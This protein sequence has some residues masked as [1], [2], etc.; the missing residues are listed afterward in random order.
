MNIII[1]GCGQVGQHLAEQL[2]KDKN[3]VTVID[4]SYDNLKSL[5]DRIDAMGIVGNGASQVT[6]A[7]ADI[8]NADLLIAVTNSDELNLLCC[9]IAK[10]CSNCQVIARVRSHVYNNESDFLKTELGLAMVIN[11][12]Y[13]AAQ[14][15]A[16]ILR[17]P[18]AISIETF[19]K[20]KVE[21]LKY[22]LPDDSAII[23]MSVKD[24]MMKYKSD[25]LFATIERGDK[26]YIAKGDFIFNARDVVSIISSLEASQSFFKKLGSKNQSVK[27]TMIVGAGE[28]AHYL[29]DEIKKSKMSIKV[30][31][32]D[33]ARCDDIS[34]TFPHVTVVHG[35][36]TSH[37]LMAEEGINKAGA[38]LALSDSDEENMIIS[39]HAK[40]KS[41][42]KIIT[43]ISRMDYDSVANRLGL[44]TVI[45]PKTIISDMILRYVRSA[46]NTRGSNMETLYNVI[47][48]EVEASEFF[49]RKPSEIVGVPI[50]KLRF[51]KNVLIAAILR[52]G[53][54]IM[55]RGYDT[56]EMGDSVVI[57][58]K[59]T[60]LRDITDIIE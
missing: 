9:T 24:V 4:K 1:V 6:L 26:A 16:R 39:M 11:P 40:E 56:I 22:K 36:T 23:G 14:E 3:N 58:S 21:L 33:M 10:K 37:E 13:V 43:K 5:T 27:S 52:N 18:S 15:I 17:S 12:D 30:I 25:I 38:F 32:R 7:E 45:Y 44:D 55:P 49:I 28:I 50:S 8:E 29:C 35:D 46:N 57:V 41:G 48:G 42:A 20:G 60:G 47:P 31:E 59:V 19:G 54:V 53:E 51:K 34:S 2:I